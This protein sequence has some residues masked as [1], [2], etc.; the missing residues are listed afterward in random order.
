MR[1]LRA[2]AAVSV[3]AI[4]NVCGGAKGT[5]TQ[6]A[7]AAIGAL[8]CGA[9]AAA[10]AMEPV[11]ADVSAPVVMQAAIPLLLA[12]AA[13]SRR[14]LETG[15]KQLMNASGATLDGPP[16]LGAPPTMPLCTTAQ[17]MQAT[18]RGRLA[19]AR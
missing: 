9:V 19:L 3:T 13:T 10:V 8:P 18:A 7:A 4:I 17:A 16:L 15:S 12:V 14:L 1:N 6:R 5:A 11:A 2:A